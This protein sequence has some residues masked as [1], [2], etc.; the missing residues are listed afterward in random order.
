[1]R[2][3]LV[4]TAMALVLALG[5]W[6]AIGASASSPKK[7]TTAPVKAQVATAVV[8]GSHLHAGTAATVARKVASSRSSVSATSPKGANPSESENESENESEGGGDN[9][10]DTHEDPNGQDVNHECPPNCDTG[11]GEQP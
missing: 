10:N 5:L 6:F 3:L 11:N 2:K 7:P 8:S 1:M 9:E 4:G